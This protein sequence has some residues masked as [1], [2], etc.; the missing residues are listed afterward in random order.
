M[1]S[2]T[3]GLHPG[4]AGTRRAGLTAA[5]AAQMTHFFAVNLGFLG[6]PAIARTLEHAFPP[7]AGALVAVMTAPAVLA[8][9][10]LHKRLRARRA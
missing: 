1:G 9:G 3:T 2:M 7:L 8:A 5:A 10:A 6:V 4:P